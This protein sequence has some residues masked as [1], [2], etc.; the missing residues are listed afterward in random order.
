MV[1]HTVQPVTAGAGA[2]GATGATTTGLGAGVGAGAGGFGWKNEFSAARS[3]GE[4]CPQ[5][6]RM[7][8][9]LEVAQRWRK[10]R[11][12]ETVPGRSGFDDVQWRCR[13][14]TRFD[15]V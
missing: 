8:N 12:S 14:R 1:S 11:S 6:M 13:G 2:D 3:R 7:R 9:S 15:A 10:A 4:A 5:V